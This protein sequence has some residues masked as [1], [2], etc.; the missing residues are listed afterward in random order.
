MS[1]HGGDDICIDVWNGLREMIMEDDRPKALEKI[2]RV[3]A[4]HDWTPCV[5]DLE[6]QAWPELN[7]ALKLAGYGEED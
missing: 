1:W 4:D 6:R 2:I 3:L 5:Y 7:E